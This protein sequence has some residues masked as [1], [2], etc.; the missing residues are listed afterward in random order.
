MIWSGCHGSERKPAQYSVTQRALK[1]WAE[2]CLAS[3]HEIMGILAGL[4]LPISEEGVNILPWEID[5]TYRE[6]INR[7]HVRCACN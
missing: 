4:L 2:A 7:K 5:K 3:I 6:A 1:E